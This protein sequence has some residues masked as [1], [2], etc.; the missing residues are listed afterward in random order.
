[1]R[2]CSTLAP[3]YDSSQASLYESCFRQ[4]ASFTAR[5]SALYTPSTSVQMEMLDAISSAPKMVAE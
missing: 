5:G 2:G 4:T 1:M 3:K